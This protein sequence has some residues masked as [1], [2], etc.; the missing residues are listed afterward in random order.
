MIVGVLVSVWVARYLG[1]SEFGILNY[2]MLFPTVLMSLAGFGLTN[3]LLIDFVAANNDLEKQHRL[4]QLGLFIKLMFGS[5]AY[6]ISCSLNYILNKDNPVLFQLINLTGVILILQSSDIIDT[7]FQSQ[8]KAKLSIV[9]KLIAFGLASLLRIYALKNDKKINF[10]VVINII[11]SLLVYVLSLMVY[12]QKISSLFSNISQA[13]NLKLIKQ[14]I[15]TAWP[16]M[17]TEFFVFVYMRVDQ[18]MI[19]ELSTNRELGLYGA[20]LRLSEA[21]YFIAGAI[22]TSFYPKIAE[23]WLINRE[24][25]YNQYQSLLNILT[26]MSIGLSI[27]VSVSANRL[28]EVLYGPDF[29]QAGSILSVHIWAGVFVF[30]GVGTN[31]L[32]IV[33]NLQKFVLIKTITGALLNVLL[34]F[35]LIPLYGA[36]GA[37]IATFISY[38]FQAYL[39]NYFLKEA[40]PIFNLQSQSFINFIT[41]KRPIM[42][43]FNFKQL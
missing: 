3:I 25:F 2:A 4:T 1:P 11:E 15:Q 9:V 17:I 10:L 30:I 33:N 32:M 5:L 28:I 8:T 39:L 27:F 26:Y 31:N 14:M 38:G 37:S 16:I 20:A 21:W 36:M 22:T 7:Y 6:V 42:A 35:W 12:Q 13:V 34:N 19:E 24:K 41:L 43:K 18:F 29:Q 23:Y 40:R